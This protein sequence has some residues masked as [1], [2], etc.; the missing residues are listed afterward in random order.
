MLNGIG[1]GV[2]VVCP[3]CGFG[4]NLLIDP[5]SRRVKPYPGEPNRGKLCPKDCMLWSMYSQRID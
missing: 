3:Y 1:M 2:R 4:C 5:K